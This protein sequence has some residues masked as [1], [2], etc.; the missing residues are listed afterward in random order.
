MFEPSYTSVKPKGVYVYTHSR[1]T[2]GTL[3]YVGAGRH[4]RAWD[5][6]SGRNPHWANI[7]R[8]HRVL[9]NVVKDGMTE[10]DAFDLEIKLISIHA[11]EA[12]YTTG[13]E[14]KSG[15]PSSDRQKEAAVKARSKPVI[16]SNGE[17]FPSATIA[18]R[19][20]NERGV[21]IR[22][23]TISNSILT[24]KNS[25]GMSWSFYEKGCSS[26]K[27]QNYRDKMRGNFGQSVKCSNG[28][29]FGSY[30]EAAE[31]LRRNGHPKATGTPISLCIRGLSKLSYGYD[32][33]LTDP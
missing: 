16:N 7:A 18:A 28:M 24:G 12:N 23:A 2:D 4:R 8:K 27:Y 25:H 32:W 3:F 5:K 26:P 14:G 15:I 31:W 6:S 11:P 9:V 19:I 29:V 21:G 10:R 22:R 17:V 33:G 30:A 13:G 1:A 20:L